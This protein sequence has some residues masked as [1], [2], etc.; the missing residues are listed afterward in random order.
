MTNPVVGTLLT[1]SA[2]K[3]EPALSLQQH[4]DDCLLI[5]EQLQQS[6]NQRELFE[7]VLPNF[8][9]LLKTCVIFH[10]LG[11][12]HQEFQKVLKGETNQWHSQRHE[13]FSLPFL[14]AFE[15]DKPVKQLVRLVVAGHHKSFDDL[16][17]YI[18]RYAQDDFAMLSGL[19]EEDNSFE[20]E[21]SENVDVEKIKQLL[22]HYLINIALVVSKPIEGLIR[23]YLKA[24]YDCSHADY[25]KLLLLFGGMKH[26][27]H[28]GSA[29]VTHIPN[30]ELTD[31]QFLYNKGRSFYKHQEGCSAVIGNLILTAPTGSGKTES[32]FLWLRNQMQIFGQGRV[33]Y[34]LPFTASIN[35]MYERLGDEVD[36]E[37]PEKKI[38]MLHGKLSDY[39]NNYF[40]DFQY[41]ISEK[42]E[43]ISKI[44]DKFKTLVTPVKVV[45]PFQLLKHLFGLK[46]FEQG[47]FEW[48]GSYFIFDEI[49]AYS[50]EVFAQIKVLLEFSIKHL[51]TKV[52]IMT[53]T[54]PSFLKKELEFAIGK[55]VEIKASQ[56]LYESFTRHRIILK[57]GLLSENIG[58]IRT[59]LQAGK[60][61]LV[62]CNTVRQAQQVFAAL[63]NVVA[64]PEAVLLHS[65]FNGRDR[66]KKERQL[67]GENVKLLVGTQAI[68]VSLD[69]DYDLIYSEPAPID[70]LIQRFGRVNR[71][72][73]KGICDCYIFRESN[74]NDKHIYSPEIVKRTLSALESIEKEYNGIINEELLQEMIDSV[75]P[76]WDKDSQEA[77]D[78]I[79]KLLTDSVRDNLSPLRHSK[80]SEEDFYRQFDGIK[81]LPQKEKAEF[82]NKLNKFDFI[83]AE[84]L[85]VQIRKRT[86]AWWIQA[87]YLRKEMHIIETTK[88][89]L[90]EIPYFITNT[91]YNE[92]VGLIANEQDAWVN[93]NFFG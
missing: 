20:T 23:S 31:F 10:D 67:K 78:K 66:N 30:F 47:L 25:F 61:V 49:H 80:H 63:K 72:R 48:M 92:E 18:K 69:I 5:W 27:D 59:D 73:E 21:F 44:R 58:L 54:M 79:Y 60:K 82:I 51:H 9:Q 41:G 40:E 84:S 26:C 50:P 64:E 33:F 11:K 24:P 76:D 16:T 29:R 81:I 19:D 1:K 75:Y 86:F 15:L 46:G 36:K 7:E 28:L 39:L 2:T 70:A 22:Q 89:K 90:I 17:T 62:V 68:E 37:K 85:K 88:N 4:M 35:A 8:W 6:F 87:E 32:A 52:M 55:F 53:A 34:V 65:A 45:T 13:L 57:K 42:K 56:Q 74:G 3:T 38:G 43:E 14:E 77:F 91:S 12:A 83:G 71:R 93:D